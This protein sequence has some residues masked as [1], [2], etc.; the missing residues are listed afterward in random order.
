MQPKR[1]SVL[2]SCL[3]PFAAS[4]LFQQPADSSPTTDPVKPLVGALVASVDITERDGVS[5]TPC[6]IVLSHV[7]RQGDVPGPLVVQIDGSPVETQTDI[8]V[9]WSDGSVKHAIISF[10]IPELGANET[11]TAALHV[12]NESNTYGKADLSALR[13]TSSGG[14]GTAAFD[15]LFDFTGPAD[16]VRL[17][18]LLG[19]DDEEAGRIE[20]WL[21]GKVVNEVTVTNFPDTAQKLSLRA[22]V[23]RFAG[24][25]GVRVFHVVENSR[26]SGGGTN[27]TYSL[28]VT[29]SMVPPG[30][31][32]IPDPVLD[33]GSVESLWDSRH[34][35]VSWIGK[36]PSRVHIDYDI[37]YLLST[38]VFP[39]YD[40]ELVV[41]P[42]AVSSMK[43]AWKACN[44]GTGYPGLISTYFP[45]TGWRYEI[46][47][48]PQ[49]AAMYLLT[50]DPDLADIVEAHGVVSGYAQVHV[51]ETDA[52]AASVNRFISIDDRPQVWLGDSRD[53]NTPNPVVRDWYK[54]S[55][56]IDRAH[57]GSLAYLPYL[58]T[59]DRFYLEELYFWNAWNLAAGWPHE[60]QNEKG[61]IKDQ[62]RG[63]AWTFRELGRVAGI[64]PEEDAYERGYFSDKI[65]NTLDFWIDRY[66]TNTYHPLGVWEYVYQ[67]GLAGGRPTTYFD[68]SV[69]FI[70][71]PWQEFF[72][73]QSLAHVND[74]LGGTA[75]PFGDR[76]DRVR[77][78][79]ASSLVGL[80]DN[81][82]PE[83]AFSYRLPVSVSTHA[84][85][86]AVS[87]IFR[88]EDWR[89]LDAWQDVEACYIKDPA[90]A[91][92]WET[93]APRPENWENPQDG[94][95]EAWPK[96]KDFE[97][98]A[99]V[100]ACTAIDYPLVGL[101]AM[102]C[103][104][105]VEGGEAARESM[106]ALLA[107]EIPLYAANPT[108]ALVP[109]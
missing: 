1:F 51:R 42:V 78:Y 97:D 11:R 102:A 6:P 59:G 103:A 15:A 37:G 45:N 62:V 20:T 33:T 77:R 9:R 3:L 71:T 38:G 34:G 14:T 31:D 16:D 94:Y 32:Q 4:C 26:A 91:R 24:Y 18:E 29:G 82:G 75:G 69:V 58:M 44:K 23:R 99:G 80:V 108:F 70:S 92:L 89:H 96:S 95:P 76:I 63:D 19:D 30:P 109:R 57:Q 46:G 53:A 65:S 87:M 84:Y 64:A 74:L 52:G 8:Q 13:G 22:H 27:E 5:N 81:L 61:I 101:G 104:C 12:S 25:P 36:K 43:D 2:L 85:P 54:Y 49:F 93:K 35:R 55:W 73:L 83:R 17:S 47:L 41:D 7:F 105:D 90:S 100:P 106:R 10:L 60:R 40:P 86:D 107:D 28:V 39:S 66:I 79:V 50:M 67:R 72:L 21:A 98:K 88:P 48:L 56:T 68:Y